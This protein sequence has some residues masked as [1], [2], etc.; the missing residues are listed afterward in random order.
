M[1]ESRSYSRHPNTTVDEG[2]DGSNS[3]QRRV[4]REVDRE[5]EKKREEERRKGN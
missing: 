1:E 3:N 5:G 2:V 4:G